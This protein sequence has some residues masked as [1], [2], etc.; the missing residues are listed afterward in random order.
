M[1]EKTL[2]EKMVSS[3]KAV[4]SEAEVFAVRQHPLDELKRRTKSFLAMVGEACNLPLSR[5]DW[6]VKPDRTIIRLPQG[7]RAV[8]FHAS[9]AMKLVTGLNP[10]E[11]LFKKT[12]ER[13]KLVKLVEE[14]A[15]RL[16]ISEW[17]RKND[18]LAFERLWQIKASA[19]DRK[20]ETVEPVLCRVVGAYRHFVAELPVWG[21][22]SVAINL[23]AEGMLD[24]LTV[25]VREPTDEVIDRAKILPPDEAARQIF[26]QLKT[27]MG[28][29][30]IPV[31]E[32]AT[33]KWLR[34]GY[35]SLAK[36][37]AQHLLAPAYVAAIGI[38]GQEEAQA[39]LVAISATERTYLPLCLSGN[40]APPAPLR[41]AG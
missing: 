19:A 23:A 39:Y 1:D 24:S 12:Q 7:A 18:S 32:V 31:N 22:A 33:P 30:K 17:V 40:E 14:T 4:P 25:Q 29:S 16:N 37:K 5:G 34:F 28:K 36:R 20:G 27:L 6:V 15:D 2:I 35:L 9:G 21:A 38:D 3:V 8:V 41:C 26:L 11:S 13:E 10:M